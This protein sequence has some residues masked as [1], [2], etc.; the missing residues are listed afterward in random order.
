MI[1]SRLLHGAFITAVV[2]V[3][4]VLFVRSNAPDLQR[5]LT[6]Q[7]TL[8]EVA[9]QEEVLKRDVLR[10][11]SGLLHDYDPL[12]ATTRHIDGLIGT[13]TEGPI[14]ATAAGQAEIDQLIE[15]YA[16]A[17]A[18]R[19]DQLE[20]FKAKDAVFKNSLV[21]LPTLVGDL[22][23]QADAAGADPALTLTIGRL[24]GDLMADYAHGGLD[25]SQL[26]S[27]IGDLVALSN[28]A[29][30]ALGDNI[31]MLV[32]HAR[33]IA[34]KDEVDALI[35]Q[36]LA[37][38]ESR[39]LDDL[40][41]AFRRHS[42]ATRT[43]LQRDTAALYA[44][45][46]LLLGYVVLIFL[47]LARARASLRNANAELEQRVSERT[48]AL[49][50]EVNRRERLEEALLQ[51]AE[52]ARLLQEIA[53]AA[54][55]CRDAEQAIQVC[56]DAVCG[57]TGWP[58]G[59]AYIRADAGTDELTPTDLWHLDRPDL[60]DDFRRITMQT[61]FAAGVDLPG[62]ALATR[63]PV[64]IADVTRDESCLRRQAAD[65]AGLGCC[66]AVPVLV[67]L[68]VMAVLE[69]FSRDTVVPPK[70]LRETLV[71]VANQLGRA[72][73]RQQSVAALQASEA[74]FSGI[75]D[76]A[77]EAIISTDETL[78]I[79]L[80]NKGAEAIFG[81]AAHE[82]MGQPVDTLIPTGLRA[83]HG[84]HV[85]NFARDGGLNR[86]AMDRSEIYGLMKNG[87]VFPAAASVSKLVK[88]ATTT[89]TVMLRD[90]SDGKRVEEAI[91]TAKEQAEAAN[92]AK[93]EF[94][95]NM[96]HELRTPLNG[97]I[98]FSEI[99]RC[100]SL[101][102]IGNDKYTE[103]AGDI[104]A[105]GT[106]LLSVINDILDL[107]KIEAGTTELHEEEVDATDVLA[108]CLA[109]VKQRAHAAG[110]A[111]V[112]EAEPDLPS[113][114]ADE[115]KVKQILINLLSNAV[116]FTPAGGQV[117]VRAWFRADGGFV[118]QIAD[119]GIGIAVKDIPKALAP[120][121]QVDSALNRKYE[122][123]GLG[124]PLTKSLV[125]LHGGSLDLQSEP[126]VGTTVTVRFPAWRVDGA[127][128]I[129][130]PGPSGPDRPGALPAQDH[131]VAADLEGSKP[132]EKA[133]A[134]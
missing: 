59:H 114:H 13:L 82:V 89:Y 126:G 1:T 54:S 80:F 16:A 76:M 56:L 53:V 99:I 18:A 79:T 45:A 75:L 112:C 30:G 71:Q 25:T 49:Q 5:Q 58:V 122:G 65:H 134:E 88:G 19:Q 103:Y 50:K 109:L 115:R 130:T 35:G 41:A 9:R 105:A 131:D 119:T 23:D 40:G 116:K 106:H 97:I 123:T 120:F 51:D 124:L 7:T 2:G 20:R 69:F 96:S 46:I 67:G 125:E 21:Y 17:V 32:R 64:C 108:S 37:G 110:V 129:A 44:L 90:I 15:D 78:S 22:V 43:S 34:A 74:R 72:L 29:V 85:D 98:G 61:R 104:N 121:R 86:L 111:I 26:D 33:I 3:A 95:A 38:D 87:T 48:E 100:G 128:P 24:H 4:T 39:I 68:R 42:L 84:R 28:G 101:G 107:S 77:P 52:A 12:V 47:G 27:Q 70:T 62:I 66:L 94:L 113:L 117:S 127:A 6:I 60:F 91:F 55:E 81:Y 63:Q 132:L 92:R 36:I 8:V 73:E 10:L 11:R 57:L 133:D 31:A 102:P 93:S 14:V 118:F 83:A